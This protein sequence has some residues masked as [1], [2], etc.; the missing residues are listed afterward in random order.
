M[1]SAGGW[2]NSATVPRVGAAEPQE[3]VDGRRLAGAVGAEQRDDLARCDRQ[4]DAVDG[5]GRAVRLAQARARSTAGAPGPAGGLWL[6]VMR[7]HSAC[8]VGRRPSAGRRGPAMTSVMRRPG[9]PVRTLRPVADAAALEELGRAAA[10]TP[11]AYGLLPW[12]RRRGGRR[13]PTTS[14][15][16]DGCRL[17]PH[18]LRDVSSVTHRRHRAGH[19]GGGAGARRADRVPLA[20]PPRRRGRHRARRR[21]GGLADG[22]VDVRHPAARG[23]RRSRARRGAGGSRSTSPGPRL[24]RELARAPPPPATA[25]SC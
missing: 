10:W 5:L 16:G 3:D 14:R 18:V 7:P 24:D 25:P 23:G 17:R 4:V 2:P 8:R 20:G 15:P 9:R 6:S 11:P 12:R 19:A 22:A 1:A 21:G 13:S